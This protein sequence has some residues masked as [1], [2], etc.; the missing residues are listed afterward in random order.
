MYVS[1]AHP[2]V[3]SVA[4]LTYANTGARQKLNESDHC[5]VIRPASEPYD[6]PALKFLLHLRIIGSLN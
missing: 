2:N 1:L 4:L 5:Q 6:K 3:R